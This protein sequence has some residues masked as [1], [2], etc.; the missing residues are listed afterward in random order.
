MISN[1]RIAYECVGMPATDA[2]CLIIWGHGWGQ[3]RQVFQPMVQSL[4]SRAAHLLIDFPGFG[5]S[6]MPPE[7]W[8]TKDYAE[9]IVPLIESF[10]SVKKIIWVGHSFG[11]RVGLQLGAS[12]ADLVDGIFLIASAGLPRR[13]GVVKSVAYAARIYIYKALKI[14][15][16]IMHINTH[17][18]R[19]KFGSADYLNAG[20]MRPI[21]LNV[22]RENLSRQ[23]Q[24]LQCPTFFVYGAD[25]K[26]TPPEIGQR[27]AKLVPH[28]EIVVLPG[29]DHYSLL[30]SGRHL[31]LKYLADF[32]DKL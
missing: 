9:A 20:K 18:L 12:H 3:S 21:F 30:G 16:H 27:L 1:S 5:E 15:F 24:R 22:I 29:Q 17:Q 7:S 26:E 31:V 4:A 6:A 28:A 2:K 11:G 19:K 25:D 14:I 8:G 32:M 13:R 10:R 23:A